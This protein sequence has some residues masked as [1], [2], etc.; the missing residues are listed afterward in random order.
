MENV[1]GNQR[2][3]RKHRGEKEPCTEGYAKAGDIESH[4][5]LSSGEYRQGSRV[6][7]ISSAS[8]LR[9]NIYKSCF[10]F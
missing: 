6:E 8:I 2:T 1:Q 9:I 7:S 10:H 5:R 3:F 4:P